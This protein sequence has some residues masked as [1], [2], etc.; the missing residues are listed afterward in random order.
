MKKEFEAVI[1]KPFHLVVYHIGGGDGS[2]GLT[3]LIPK[4]FPD[5]V[6]LVEFEIRSNDSDPLTLKKYREDWPSV[7][8]VARCVAGAKRETLFNVNKYPL[9]SSLLEP[10][11]LVAN[12]DPGYDARGGANW[13]LNTAID[14]KISV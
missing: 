5:N 9:S 8:S 2:F 11:E 14:E 6:L 12:E 1:N 10:S 3:D 4:V 13:E 7:V